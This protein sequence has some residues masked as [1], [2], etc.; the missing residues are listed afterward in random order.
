MK[1][2]FWLDVLLFISGL[3]CISTGIILDLHLIEITDFEILH[4]LREVHIYSGYIMAVGILLH[5][6]WHAGW[7]KTV[8]KQLFFK[9]KQEKN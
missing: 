3:I 4:T 9:N 6:A 5:I 2:N 1:K 7:I 8:T